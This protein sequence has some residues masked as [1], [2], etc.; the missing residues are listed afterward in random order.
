MFRHRN[1]VNCPF[2]LSESCILWETAELG[3]VEAGGAYS[4]QYALNYR[5]LQPIYMS[6]THSH[7]E[8]QG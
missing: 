3:N 1:G 5:T 2:L 7:S 6:I 4:Y 8:V